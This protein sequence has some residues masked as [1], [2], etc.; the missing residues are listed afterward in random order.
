MSPWELLKDSGLAR[1]E[2]VAFSLP[3]TYQ[4]T[5]GGRTGLQCHHDLNV[6]RVA[7]RGGEEQLQKQPQSRAWDRYTWGFS[8]IG[9]RAHHGFVWLGKPPGSWAV[10]EKADLQKG[11]IG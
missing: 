2:G 10:Q 7:P 8:P 5:L 6:Q 1:A 11:V 4:A 9:V 3:G